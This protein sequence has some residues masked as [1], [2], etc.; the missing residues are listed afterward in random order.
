MYSN[1]TMIIVCLILAAGIVVLLFLGGMCLQPRPSLETASNTTAICFRNPANNHVEKFD[2]P[3]LWTL[4][5]GAFYFLSKGIWTHFLLYLL[6]VPLTFGLAW[7]VYP[8]FAASIVESHCLRKGWIKELPDAEKLRVDVA[9]PSPRTSHGEPALQ[10]ATQN[11]LSVA[12]EI[13]KL[14]ALKE[15]GIITEEE[16]QTQKRNLIRP[17]VA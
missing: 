1:T 11:V 12:T 17:S 15:R 9:L 5:F 7:F 2:R 16:F 8:F 10:A 13:E 6:L 14:A 3:W 4:L